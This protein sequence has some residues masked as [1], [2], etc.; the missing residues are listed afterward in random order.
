MLPFLALLNINLSSSLT[1]MF[2]IGF[3]SVSSK[4][5][6]SI[7]ISLFYIF[8]S[9][10]QFMFFFKSQSSLALNKFLIVLDSFT[11][12]GKLA[13]ESLRNK[14]FPL[15]CMIYS[16]TIQASPSSLS[17][18]I[19]CTEKRSSSLASCILP[20]LNFQGMTCALTKSQTIFS[21]S[22]RLHLTSKELSSFVLSGSSC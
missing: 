15:S 10:R 18:S 20:P 1:S 14:E 3:F 7:L 12:E 9:E 6:P 16:L 21:N 13:K 4:S 2:N 11:G 22:W 19:F 8:D 5:F 17:F